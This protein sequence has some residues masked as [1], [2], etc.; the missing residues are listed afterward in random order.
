MQLRLAVFTVQTYD[1]TPEE[2]AAEMQR[3]GYDGVEWRVTNLPSEIPANRNYWNGNVCAFE[4]DRIEAE[5]ARLQALSTAHGLALPTLGT[6]LDCRKLD[7]IDACLRAAAAV[8]APMLRVSPP[9]WD[10]SVPW[11]AAF[12]EAIE[13][14]RPVVDLGRKYGVRILAELHHNSL[15][16]SASAMRRFVEHF[17]PESVGVIYDPGNMVHEG[18]E[19]PDL[20]IGVLGPYLAHVHVKNAR[21]LLAGEDQG[22]ARWRGEMCRLTEGQVVWPDILKALQRQGYDGW[23]ATEDFGVGD[24]RE[25]L[26][27]NVATL[28]EWAAAL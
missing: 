21:W 11:H 19:H 8:G 7:L 1:L 5:A 4:I 3:L 2:A 26:A 25:K 22:T 17:E 15:L 6:Y 20:S 12:A 18:W 10:H 16:P 28:R 9:G 14:W 23:F 27:A 24:T 13:L